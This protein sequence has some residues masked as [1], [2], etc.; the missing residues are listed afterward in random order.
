DP[1]A[2]PGGRT[3]PA[4]GTSGEAGTPGWG[5][6]ITGHLPSTSTKSSQD[7]D[8]G[9]DVSEEE[10]AA[11]LLVYFHA[12]SGVGESK[13]V[14]DSIEVLNDGP[15]STHAVSSSNVSSSPAVV[16]PEMF[17]KR[18]RREVDEGFA[19][20]RLTPAVQSGNQATGIG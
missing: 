10:E 13:A 18:K 7:D 12:R 2:A 17:R 11:D 3:S 19:Q 4:S 15:G 5:T 6:F 14:D 20:K 16:A 9:E 8:N 1:S